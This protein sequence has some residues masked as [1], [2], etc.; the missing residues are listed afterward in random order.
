MLLRDHSLKLNQRVLSSTKILLKTS[1][2]TRTLTLR[3]WTL[4]NRK[5]NSKNRSYKKKR[6]KP[7]LLTFSLNSEIVSS[8]DPLTWL[9]WYFLT[10][11]ARYDLR[12]KRKRQMKRSSNSKRRLGNY[13]HF[14]TRYR[15]TTSIE[16]KVRS[17]TALILIHHYW[18]S[19]WRLSSW[20]ARLKPATWMSTYSFAKTSSRNLMTQ[21]TK[22]WILSAF[23]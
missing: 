12:K 14:W 16:Y 2:G 21:K 3:V 20:K 4:R 19:W 18:K 10:R 13:V 1:V 5:R 23:C 11:N 22:K 7:I 6:R 8:K 9:Y 15:K 17:W